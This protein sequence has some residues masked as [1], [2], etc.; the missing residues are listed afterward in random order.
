MVCQTSFTPVS[1]GSK[2]YPRSHDPERR[3]SLLK[4]YTTARTLNLKHQMI[5][6]AAKK[7]LTLII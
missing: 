3:D 2:F 4:E 6:L 1:V 7:L 5:D